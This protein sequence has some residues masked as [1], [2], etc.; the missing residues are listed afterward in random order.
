MFSL[1][2]SNRENK[3]RHNKQEREKCQ[4]K[5]GKIKRPILLQCA[6][7]HAIAYY[8][9]WFLCVWMFLPARL[10]TRSKHSIVRYICTYPR[11]V[12][13]FDRWST[14]YNQNSRLPIRYIACRV[15]CSALRPCAPDIVCTKFALISH[16]KCY[17]NIIKTVMKIT[18]WSQSGDIIGC[19]NASR[20]NGQFNILKA[21]FA[22]SPNVIGTEKSNNLQLIRWL[23]I[24]CLQLRSKANEGSV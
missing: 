12:P 17:C 13:L 22:H 7:F 11:L 3:R 16:L 20:T 19:H 15:I 14:Q 4:S 24:K 9:C 10:R 1:F 23:D 6:T 18:E 21:I 2:E 5:I 8:S